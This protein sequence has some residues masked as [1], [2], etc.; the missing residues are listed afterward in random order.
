ME[1]I[2][3]FE[4]LAGFAA[5]VAALI[6]AG[7]TFGVVK[8][9]QAPIYSAIISL[10]GMIVFIGFKLFSPSIDVIGWDAKL[11][12]VADVLIYALGIAVSL[13]LPGVFHN[14]FKTSSIP[15]IGKS[16]TK[17]GSHEQA[18]G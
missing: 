14:I 7:K 4:M 12:D 6:N 11:K 1:I 18:L 17:S 15:V 9:G 10:L 3:Q 16:F 5:F 8:D 2:Q 13:G